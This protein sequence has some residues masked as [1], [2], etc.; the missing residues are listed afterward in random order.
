M[1]RPKRS[2]CVERVQRL[3]Q[4]SARVS[5]DALRTDHLDVPG[6]SAAL[7]SVVRAAVRPHASGVSLLARRPARTSDRRGAAGMSGAL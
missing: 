7:R 5:H 2:D 6:C 1:A 4:R 3:R